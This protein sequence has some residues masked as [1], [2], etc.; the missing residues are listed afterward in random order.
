[1]FFYKFNCFIQWRVW[2]KPNAEQQF[3]YG[4]NIVKSGV[5]RMTDGIE[6]RQGVVVYNMTDMPL[7]F[8][9][10]SKGTADC[11]KADPT[12]LV[13]LHQGDLG[14]YIRHEETLI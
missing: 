12:A 14:E 4:N 6:A 8:G 2:L 1:M 10:T 3:L 5:G 11:R 9:V 7:G 13:V